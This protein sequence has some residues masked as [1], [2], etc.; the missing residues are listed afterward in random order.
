[1]RDKPQIKTI[2]VSSYED[3]GPCGAKSIAEIGI[4]GPVP[5]IANAIYNAVGVRLYEAPFTPEKIWR[6]INAR[7]AAQDSH[8]KAVAQEPALH[9]AK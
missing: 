4:N 9:P 7:Q 5:A 3:S 2:L 8:P 6:A 1:V